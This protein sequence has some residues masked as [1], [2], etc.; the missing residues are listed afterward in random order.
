MNG[1]GTV[2][3]HESPVIKSLF[4]FKGNSKFKGDSLDERQKKKSFEFTKNR[5]SENRGLILTSS[6]KQLPESGQTNI[7]PPSNPFSKPGQLI[8]NPFASASDGSAKQTNPFASAAAPKN[9]SMFGD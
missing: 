3:T 9:G 4:D 8:T 6:K 5:D 1:D 7:Q 2:D